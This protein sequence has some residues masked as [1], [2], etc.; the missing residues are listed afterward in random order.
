MLSGLPAWLLALCLLAGVALSALADAGLKASDID[1]VVLVGGMTR[2]PRVREVVKDFFGKE[3]KKGISP[4]EVVALGAATY[5]AQLAGR[6]GDE[7]FSLS[8]K[9]PHSLSLETLNNERFMVIQKGTPL[10][11]KRVVQLTTSV[12]NAAV[13]GIHL[14]EGDDEFGR[15]DELTLL[16]R[17]YPEVEPSVA[18]EPT[19]E[20]VIERDESGG[21]RVTH[22]DRVIYEAA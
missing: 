10:P 6:G 19:V 14:L 2:M 7:A 4:E 3:P 8:G 5:A 11:A 1:D 21:V 9:A 18:G 20:I 13:V 17:D 12:D 22:N 15:A 16:C